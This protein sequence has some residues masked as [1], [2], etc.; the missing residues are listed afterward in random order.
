MSD[1][2]GFVDYYQQCEDALKSFIA[3]NL[4]DYFVHDWQLTDDETDLLRGADVFILF[5]PGS[6]P[7]APA[8]FQTSSFTYVDWRVNCNLFVKWIIKKQQW[9]TFKRMR[10]LVW[11]VLENNQWLPNNANVEKVVSIGFPEE[12]FYW[13][14][15]N[16]SESADPNMMAQ[17][18]F[19]VVRQRITHN[20]T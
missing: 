7:E 1:P 13:K 11:F 2:A 10:A 15:K 16:T 4:S 20:N 12:P 19:V 9:P 6:K 14:F 18:M 8:T 3:D 5:R 17:P